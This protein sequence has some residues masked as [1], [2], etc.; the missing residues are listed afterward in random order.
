MELTDLDKLYLALAETGQ[1]CAFNMLYYFLNITSIKALKEYNPIG[2][3]YK[4]ILQLNDIN[5]MKYN[6]CEK[7]FDFQQLAVVRRR[8][9]FLLVLL[10][11]TIMQSKLFKFSFLEQIVQAYSL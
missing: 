8:Q 11:F 6:V 7:H 5:T 4:K 10:M 9:A 2:N 3:N 1:D